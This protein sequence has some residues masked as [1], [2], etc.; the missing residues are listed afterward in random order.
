MGNYLQFVLPGIMVQAV[1]FITM[2]TGVAVNT[3][4]SK[5]IAE[6]FRTLPIWQ[7]STIV[8]ALLGD[9]LRYTL[10]ATMV[11]LLGLLLGFRPAGGVTG[12]VMAV[13]LVVVFAFSLSWAWTMLGM[14][15]RTPTSVMM[16][17][18]VLLFPLTFVS[19]VYIDPETMPSWLQAAVNVNPIARLATASRGL[20]HGTAT[21]DEIVWVLVAC[22]V[23]TAIFAPLTMYLYRNKQ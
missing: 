9:A 4:Q 11:V 13:L 7:P 14:L 1:V 23:L 19:N 10:A 15:M 8:E 18:S 16:V 20:M 3:D 22:G 5:G 17:S 6:R 12:V 2:Y 21:T